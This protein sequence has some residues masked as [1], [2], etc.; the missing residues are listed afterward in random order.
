MTWTHVLEGGWGE[1]ARP[2]LYG[3]LGIPQLFLIDL[4]G[5]IHARGLHGHEIDTAIEL[6]FSGH[7]PA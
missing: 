5:R 4:H 2:T 6:L 7:D 1:H 3:V